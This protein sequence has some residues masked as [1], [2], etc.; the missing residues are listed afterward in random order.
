MFTERR[1]GC[2]KE[3]RE[4]RGYLPLLVHRVCVCVC[5]P[6]WK[7]AIARGKAGTEV[8]NISAPPVAMESSRSA[9]SGTAGQTFEVGRCGALLLGAERRD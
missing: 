5:V 1:E 4:S 2:V 6:G 3:W 7:H 8:L 9:N